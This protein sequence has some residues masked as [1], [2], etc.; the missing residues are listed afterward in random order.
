MT[1]P[2]FRKRGYHS[3]W[4]PV[5][6]EYKARYPFC[7]GQSALRIPVAGYHIWEWT[8]LK[9]WLPICIWCSLRVM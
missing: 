2:D 5:A 8:Q 3:G 6:R 7:L 1:R 4:D 9:R